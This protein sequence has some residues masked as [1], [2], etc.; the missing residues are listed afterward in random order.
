MNLCMV[1]HLTSPYFINFHFGHQCNFPLLGN[2][3]FLMIQ[4]N[5]AFIG[6]AWTTRDI[7]TYCVLVDDRDVG[8]ND[9][10]IIA[11]N[12]VYFDNGSNKLLQN[13]CY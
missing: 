9:S 4:I 8:E 10:I 12:A 1:I 3:D 11:R 13:K 6:V 7:L 5:Q 2:T